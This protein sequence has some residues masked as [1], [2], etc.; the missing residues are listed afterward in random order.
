MLSFKSLSGL[1]L[2]NAY[3]ADSRIVFQTP[4]GE[5]L[6]SRMDNLKTW[7]TADAIQRIIALEEDPAGGPSIWPAARK[8]TLGGGI[9][10][11]NV[12]IDGSQDVTLTASIAD[13]SIPQV[14]IIGLGA[15]FTGYD[16]QIAGINT[17]LGNKADKN[18]THGVTYAQLTSATFADHAPG[19]NQGNL[20]MGGQSVIAMEA[21][22]SDF[23]GQL[24][25]SSAGVYTFRTLRNDGAGWAATTAWHSGNLNIGEYA[26]LTGAAFTGSLSGR[27]YLGLDA[28]NGAAAI[29]IEKDGQATWIRSQTGATVDRSLAHYAVED[30]RVDN[31]KVYHEGNLNVANLLQKNGAIQEV[32]ADDPVVYSGSQNFNSLPP[33]RGI[34][35]SSNPN[36][37]GNSSLSW[38]VETTA[39]VGSNRLQKAIGQ[40]IGEV[41]LRAFNGT[42][43]TTWRRQWDSTNLSTASYLTRGSNGLG[44]T[45]Q[46]GGSDIDGLTQSGWYSYQGAQAPTSDV[47]YLIE[48]VQGTSTAVQTA[49]SGQKCFQRGKSSSTWSPWLEMAAGTIPDFSSKWD[50]SQAVARGLSTTPQVQNAFNSQNVGGLSH[51]VSNMASATNGPSGWTGQA[52][53]LHF[54]PGST[55]VGALAQLSLMGAVSDNP[56]LAIRTGLNGSYGAWAQVYTDKNVDINLFWAKKADLTASDLNGILTS[57]MY[58]QTLDSNATLARNYPRAN[59]GGLLKVWAPTSTIV[60]QEYSSRNSPWSYRRYLF[61]GAWSKWE[62]MFNGGTGIDQLTDNPGMA[63][64]SPS[65]FTSSGK[66]W[67]FYA[68]VTDAADGG[69]FLRRWNGSGWQNAMA[70]SAQG[71]A[72]YQPSGA[73]S[74]VVA[75]HGAVG[76]QTG[77]YG[78]FAG[79]L[80]LWQMG[81]ESNRDFKVWAYDDNGAYLS[82]PMTLTRDGR[83][84]AGAGHFNSP[85]TAAVLGCLPGGVLYLRPNGVDNGTGETQV[86]AASMRIGGGQPESQYRFGVDD[87]YFFSNTN[88]MGWYSTANGYGLRLE[89]ASKTITAF[90]YLEASDFGLTSDGRMKRHIVDMAYN[91][92]LRPRQWIDP[93]SGETHLGFVSQEVQ[94]NYPS[95]VRPDNN[96]ILR[97]A[98]PRMVAVVSHQVNAVEDE[99]EKLKAENEG[100]KHRLQMLEDLVAG[101]VKA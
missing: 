39:V 81:Y 23:I 65:G 46:S 5:F 94:E 10:V 19:L 6:N 60:W 63:L 34:L 18:H 56:N 54:Q 83:V 4:S 37:P 15:T 47:G 20:T 91:G 36:S 88:N 66:G 86:T 59:V 11:G 67:Q 79:G 9:L 22:G 73:G 50:T 71:V 70:M 24:M 101:L 78:M 42:A 45:A 55:T 58:H 84:L 3:T 25:F 72:F 12:S 74:T 13:N 14:K 2:S 30:F 35:S 68:A 32:F 1:G 95:F 31:R 75:A 41:W 92:R 16:T 62:A 48:H 44:G 21:V 53:S 87:W 89:K 38:Y 27:S 17:S 51:F 33:G 96:G 49:R 82:N 29:R 77:A 28:S 57:G 64:M 80:R 69:A 90:G 61:A 52:L 85:T 76:V 93:K 99:V 8:I 40:D 7:I 26:K 97:L 98:Y 43:W 100:L